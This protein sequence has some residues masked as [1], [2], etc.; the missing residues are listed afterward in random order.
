MMCMH[1]WRLD[2]AMRRL[3]KPGTQAPVRDL[4][5]MALNPI[6][7]NDGRKVIPDMT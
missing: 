5:H 2:T 6:K 1:D 4:Y 3:A 7:L